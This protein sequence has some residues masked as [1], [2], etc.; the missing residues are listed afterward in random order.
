MRDVLCMAGYTL[1][2]GSMKAA[3]AHSERG[4]IP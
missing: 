2:A 3:A 1:L 4:V